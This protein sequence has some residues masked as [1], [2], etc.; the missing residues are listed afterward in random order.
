MSQLLSAGELREKGART[1]D[2][3]G[4][5]AGN[6]GDPLG[7][8]GTTARGWESAGSRSSAAPGDP[9]C[10]PRQ[11]P[12]ASRRA[13]APRVRAATRSLPSLRRPAPPAPSAPGCSRAGLR[14]GRQR[15]PRRSSGCQGGRG[16]PWSTTPQCRRR[17]PP[18][19]RRPL[20][21]RRAPP[22]APYAVPPEPRA[23]RPAPGGAPPGN[24]A[25]P[26]GP[27]ALLADPASSLRAGAPPPP[28]SPPAWPPRLASPQLPGRPPN[29][30]SLGSREVN[31]RDP[32]PRITSICISYVTYCKFPGWSPLE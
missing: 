22:P 11:A 14:A 9:G 1:G 15:G 28:R 4:G 7:R 24:A 17:E 13:P 27:R 3:G 26:R 12:P 20:R 16:E 31:P 25:R 8:G 29:A 23:S 10:G 32:T 18:A 5:G 19:P 6:R 30:S 2:G 21:D